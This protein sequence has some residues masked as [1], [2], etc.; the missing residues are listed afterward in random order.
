M[1]VV[2]EL[3]PSRK[4]TK[5][6]DLAPGSNAEDAI[7]ALGLFPDAWIP[8]REGSPIPTDEELRDGDLLKLIGVV[9][10]G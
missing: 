3:L 4:E 7:R 5:T 9:S 8:V 10:G 2:V 6:L 1:K